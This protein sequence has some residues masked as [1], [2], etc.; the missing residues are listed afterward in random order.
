MPKFIIIWDSG[1]G[2]TAEII[3]AKDEEEAQAVAYEAWREEVESN[4]DYAAHPYT[5]EMAK[6]YDLED[7]E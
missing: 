1:Y 6:D 5:A 4:A 3:E 2:S 7:L